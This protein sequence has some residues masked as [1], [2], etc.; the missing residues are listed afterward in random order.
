MAFDE[1]PTS[2]SAFISNS[3]GIAQTTSYAEAS[4]HPLWLE[5]MNKENVVLYANKTWELVKL[6]NGKKPIRNKLVFKAKLKSY[7]TL[8]RCKARIV[9][10]SFN[11][12]YG[13]DYEQ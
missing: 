11:Q 2:H 8:E 5:A 13:V 7:R 1:I 9:A 4:T 6:P 3:C 10:K 12:K